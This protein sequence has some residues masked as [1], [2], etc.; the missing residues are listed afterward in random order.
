MDSSFFFPIDRD[1]ERAILSYHVQCIYLWRY[2]FLFSTLKFTN[3][4]SSSN[5]EYS[6]FFPHP[7]VLASLKKYISFPF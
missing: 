3:L 4:K 6:T 7:D 2:I 5:D 1:R